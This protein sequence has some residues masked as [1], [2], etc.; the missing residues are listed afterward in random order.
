M[1]TRTASPEPLLGLAFVEPFLKILDA[2]TLVAASAT[3]KAWRAV[4]QRDSKVLWRPLVLRRWPCPLLQVDWRKRYQVLQ[5]AATAPEP[6][7]EERPQQ[8]ARPRRVRLLRHGFDAQRI[9]LH[10]SDQ[11]VS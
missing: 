5:G 4:E 2:R 11:I 3:C 8:R 1:G 10:S 9:E 7:A 6:S